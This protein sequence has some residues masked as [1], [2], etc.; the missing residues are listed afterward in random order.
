MKLKSLGFL[1]VLLVLA[2]AAVWGEDTSTPAQADETSC[3][4][5]LKIGV[6][7]YAGIS[8]MPGKRRYNDGMWAGNGTTLP[9]VAYVKWEGPNE[10]SAKLAY[11]TGEM[12]DDYP[13]QYSGPIEAY[14]QRRIGSASVTFGKFWV[15]FAQQEWMY[16]PQ[17]GAMA[18]WS[19]GRAS[20][21]A[22]ANK[23]E[24]R[25]RLNAYF[26][27]AYA[28]TD[29]IEIGA[30]AALGRGFHFDCIHDRGYALDTTISCSN[31]RFCGEYNYFTAKESDN[32]FEYLSGKLFY[33]KW[34]RVTPFVQKF[35]WADKSEAFGDFH[36]T[37][38]GVDWQI[39]PELGV[40]AATAPTSA[41][42]V[43]WL[44]VHWAWE[45]PIASE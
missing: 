33:E 9:S 8:D 19:L 13:E 1:I 18:S 22:S 25:H 16:N 11:G 3:A 14:Y 5:T 15:P 39:T 4:S 35:W 17:W 24:N 29:Q 42:D 40:Q 30:S 44:Q 43:S 38:A 21:T 27:G 6:D 37:V 45:L 26:R 7:H 41:G 32:E 23:N 31:F 20:L 36:S 12:Y 10:S 34:E 2:T 28:I